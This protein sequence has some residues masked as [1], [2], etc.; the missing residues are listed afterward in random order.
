VSAGPAALA[1]LQEWM[2]RAVTQTGLPV[3]ATGVVLPSSRLAAE[4]RMDVYRE[5]YLLRMVDVLAS[6]YRALAHFLGRRAFV[7]LARDYVHVH[8]SRSF[9]LNR[10]GRQLPDF[11]RSRPGLPSRA[12][13]HDLARLEL[14][15]AEVFH[16]AETPALSGEAIAAIP[17][18]VW[19]RAVLEPVEA[20]RLLH[21]AYPVN[22]YL[23]SVR[24]DSTVH[25]AARRRE[26]W[27]AVCRRDFSVYRLELS[28]PAYQLLVDLVGG[29][30]L[31]DAVCGAARS[32]GRRREGLTEVSG[33]FRDWIAAGMFGSISVP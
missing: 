33:W 30:P 24:D 32:H 21:F 13:C 20:L 16:A 19:E 7:E 25:P 17:A 12:F 2:V 29:R 4:E 27:L 18:G 3:A 5:M 9:G 11:V 10:L 15:V 22:A 31:G 26:T 8:P 28:R 23:Q 1:A 6:D 14:A